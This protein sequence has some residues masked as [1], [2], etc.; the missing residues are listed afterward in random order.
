VAT[1]R[2]DEHKYRVVDAVVTHF[3]TEKKKAGALSR[4]VATRK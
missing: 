2:A 3:E 4:E 1:D